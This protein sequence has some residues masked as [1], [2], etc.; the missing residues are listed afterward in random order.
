MV[1]RRAQ[2]RSPINNQSCVCKMPIGSATVEFRAVVLDVSRNGI[3]LQT[4]YKPI[5]DNLMIN[6]DASRFGGLNIFEEKAHLIVK[7]CK[8]QTV[9]SKEVYEVGCEVKC[10]SGCTKEQIKNN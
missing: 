8:R 7:W 10:E 2:I 1:N 9:G 5:Q 3:K 6:F 4:S